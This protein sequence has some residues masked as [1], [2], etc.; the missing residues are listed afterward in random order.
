MAKR[1]PLPCTPANCGENFPVCGKTSTYSH[2]KCRCDSCSAAVSEERRQ[3][4]A[5]KREAKLA[6]AKRYREDNRQQVAEKKKRYYEEN[7]EAACEKQKRYYAE[8]R[9]ACAAQGKRWREANREKVAEEQLR[10]REE[11]REKL[12]EYARQWRLANPDYAREYMRD[13][14]PRYQAEN[15]DKVRANQKR[16]RLNNP[17]RARES[18]R[19]ASHRRRARIY[20]TQVVDFTPEQLEQ[21]FAYY[22]HS[23]YLKL[24]GL[25]TGAFDQIEHVKPLSKGGAHLLANLRPSCEPCNS[26]KRAKWPFKFAA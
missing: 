22:G 23:C 15:R 25:C 2:R 18:A 4:Y 8:N 17:E 16:W 10:Y 3:H 11:N 26:H 7:R 21:K 6:Y 13:Y 24:P 1:N 12:A 14:S 19:L 5:K 9:E 20:A